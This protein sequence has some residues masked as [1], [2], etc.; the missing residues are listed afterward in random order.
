[1]RETDLLSG[2][3]LVDTYGG[4]GTLF[5]L[6][7]FDLPL[8]NG[9]SVLAGPTVLYIAPELGAALLENEFT[10]EDPTGV[11]VGSA[12]FAGTVRVSNAVPDAASYGITG[13]ALFGFACAARL[14]R[15]LAA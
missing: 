11:A 1:S 12:L 5:D 4:L 7:V 15:R 6:G 14:R 10:T 8:V 9:S 3:Y 2:L 13:L